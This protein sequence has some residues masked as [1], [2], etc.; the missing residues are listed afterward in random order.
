MDDSAKVQQLKYAISKAIDECEPEADDWHLIFTALTSV[1]MFHMA[2]L[3]PDC[4]SK[5]TDALKAN[6][7]KMHK[8]SA[9]IAAENGLPPVCGGHHDPLH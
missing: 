7:P 1:F 4:R 9:Q 2:P 8:L 5:I 6:I 3:C